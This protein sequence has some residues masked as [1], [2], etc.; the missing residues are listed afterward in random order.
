METPVVVSEPASP[1]SALGE[2][3]MDSDVVTVLL[4]LFLVLTL[5]YW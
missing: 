4:D 3:I 1:V 2:A 5:V